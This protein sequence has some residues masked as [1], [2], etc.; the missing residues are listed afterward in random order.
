[1]RGVGFVTCS[2]S[3][4]FKVVFRKQNAPTTKNAVDANGAKLQHRFV[5]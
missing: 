3:R 5:E 4:H 1:M 2:S